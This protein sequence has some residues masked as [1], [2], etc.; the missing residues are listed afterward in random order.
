MNFSKVEL[1]EKKIAEYYSAPYAVATDCCTHAIE[2]CLRYTSANRATS[3][4]KTYISVPFTFDKLGIDWNFLDHKWHNFYYVTDSIIDAAVYW[5]EKGYIS[6][7]FMCLSFQF[8]KHLSFGM[9][10]ALIY[11]WG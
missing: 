2:L 6:G 5:K 8:K 1:F 9:K 10:Y 3:P 11:R 4:K 7:T